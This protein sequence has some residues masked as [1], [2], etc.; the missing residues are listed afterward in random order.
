M[1]LGGILSVVGYFLCKGSS[2]SSESSFCV[3]R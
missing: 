3:L 1:Y 2:V